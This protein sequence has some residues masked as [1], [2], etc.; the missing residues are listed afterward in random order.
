MLTDLNEVEDWHTATKKKNRTAKQNSLIVKVERSS[1]KVNKYL[2][3][4]EEE[5]ADLSVHFRVDFRKQMDSIRDFLDVFVDSLITDW[6]IKRKIDNALH[7]VEHIFDKISRINAS[8]EQEIT[9]TRKFL[10]L[11]E[12][13]KRLLLIKNSPS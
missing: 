1:M 9:K 7:L 10:E 5:L 8:L 12:E 4:Y 13:Q 6:I 11:E 2:Q 3:R